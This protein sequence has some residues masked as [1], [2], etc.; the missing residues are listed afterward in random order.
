MEFHMAS[1]FDV[2]RGCRQIFG[3]SLEGRPD[4]ILCLF[5]HGRP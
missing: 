1:M 3:A 4:G 5:I 2:D